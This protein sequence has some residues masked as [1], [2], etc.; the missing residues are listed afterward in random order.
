MIYWE[1]TGARPGNLVAA[2][3]TYGLIA[4][5]MGFIISTTFNQVLFSPLHYHNTVCIYPFVS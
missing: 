3:Q 2:I 1:H 4:V 5:I